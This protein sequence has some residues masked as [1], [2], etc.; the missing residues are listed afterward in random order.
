MLDLCHLKKYLAYSIMEKGTPETEV[1]IS[2]VFKASIIYKRSSKTE[3]P[4][5]R[6]GGR[7]GGEK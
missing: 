3:E 4:V 5:S 1:Q 7:E 2:V 6:K